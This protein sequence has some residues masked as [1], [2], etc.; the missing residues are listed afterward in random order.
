VTGKS[1]TGTGIVG[2]SY[3]IQRSVPTDLSALLPGPAVP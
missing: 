2:G 3:R 1:A